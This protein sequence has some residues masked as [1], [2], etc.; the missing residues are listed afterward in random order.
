MP[1]RDYSFEALCEVTGADMT[2]LTKNERGRIN[3]ALK[4]LREL[5]TDDFILAAAIHD[6]AKAWATVYP[7][8][9]LT[10]QAL[11]GAWSSIEQKAA[12]TR[13]SQIQVVNA[14]PA[15]R[16]DG[17]CAT[18]GGDKMVTIVM[19]E[20]FYETVA[21]CPDCNPKANAGFWRADGSHFTPMHP[22][23][24]R[25]ILDARAD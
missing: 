19:T 16:E 20:K 15:V 9:S 2:A 14:P 5:E 12:D 18:C 6:R 23:K 4:E 7:E 24:V 25:E 13:R 3:K 1:E 10:P 8:I 21:P 17:E 11:T 22:D